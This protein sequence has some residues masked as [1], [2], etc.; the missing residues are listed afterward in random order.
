MGWNPRLELNARHGT[1][2]FGK[3]ARYGDKRLF[4][5]NGTNVG[6]SIAG[7]EAQEGL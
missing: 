1:A 6:A 3:I 5:R 2:H 7:Q 4:G